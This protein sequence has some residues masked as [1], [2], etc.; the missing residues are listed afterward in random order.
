[1][2]NMWL[3]LA[4]LP[5]LAAAG[6]DAWMHERNRQVPRIEQWLH[7]GLAVAMTVFLAAAFAGRAVVALGALAVFAALVVWDELGY[8][9]AIARSERRL[10]VVSWFALAG[11]IGTWWFVD[12]R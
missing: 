5:Y 11:F 12:L 10:H 9:R 1:M 3:G 8:H 7:G 2:R 6:A 4:L